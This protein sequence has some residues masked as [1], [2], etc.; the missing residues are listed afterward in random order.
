[1]TAFSDD[2]VSGTVPAPKGELYGFHVIDLYLAD[3]ASPNP[4]APAPGKWIASGRDGQEGE[5]L[6]PEANKFRFKVP[7]G[8]VPGGSKIVAVV[9][10]SQD[11]ADLGGGVTAT[12]ALPGRS[13]TGPAG[14]GFA[15][16][17]GSP[18]TGVV[19]RL[20]SGAVKITVSGG[21][22]PFQLQKRSVLGGTWS[23]EGAP[24]SGSSIT[25]PASGGEGYFRVVGQ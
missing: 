20:E 16:A 25:V 5:D 24:F 15:V 11:F 6:E 3:P 10:Y 7:A 21:T 4:A 13:I 19:A 18:I 14:A 23:N 9:T 22:P 17:G 8:S 1:M 12:V 2:E